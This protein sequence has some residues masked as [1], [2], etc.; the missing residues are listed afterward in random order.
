MNVIAII[1]T[2]NRKELLKECL[3]AV[4]NQ[5]HQ[6]K[7]II[8]IDNAS[9]DNSKEYIF[10]SCKLFLD[11]IDF[12]TLEKN[13]G[14][15]GGFYNGFLKAKKYDYDF[16]W[17][18]DD[19]CIPEKDCLENLVQSF[20]AVPEASFIASSIYGSNG[21]FMNVPGINLTPSKNGYVHWYEKLDKGLVLIR[22]ATFVSLL[23]SNQAIRKCGL[24]CPEYFIWGDDTEYTQRLIKYYGPAYLCG[25]SIAIHKRGNAKAL[26]I[27]N[28][29]ETSRIKMFRYFYRNTSI[30]NLFYGGK[31]KQVKFTIRQLMYAW[32]FLFSKKGFLKWSIMHKGLYEGFFNSKKFVKYINSQISRT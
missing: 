14:G 26:K 6:I 8:V 2:Y 4:N 1:V 24:P 32:I 22:N 12:E 20:S 7:K 19:D 5:T 30:N 28:E 21:E 27:Y 17:I 11:K 29:T 10:E 9:T 15:A 23:I 16:L 18:M 31:I 25:K 3:E 13:T